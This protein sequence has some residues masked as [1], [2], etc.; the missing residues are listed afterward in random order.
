MQAILDD[1]SVLE[2]ILENNMEARLIEFTFN[3]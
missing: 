2:L 3:F 1:Q